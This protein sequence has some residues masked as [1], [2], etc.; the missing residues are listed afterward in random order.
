ML[1]PIFCSTF[2]I[3]AVAVILS[4]LSWSCYCYCYG[5]CEDLADHL[6]LIVYFTVAIAS[7][8]YSYVLLL[9]LQTILICF[10]FEWYICFSFIWYIHGFIKISRSYY[11]FILL[12]RRCLRYS[13][14]YI[15]WSIAWNLFFIYLILSLLIIWLISDN[16]LDDLNPISA[17]TPI[18]STQFLIFLLWF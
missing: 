1:N 7:R 11:C 6:L 2:F 14:L 18:P 15:F 4:D 9:L 5:Y 3:V 12:L 16:H 10:I 8:S 13:W 17:T